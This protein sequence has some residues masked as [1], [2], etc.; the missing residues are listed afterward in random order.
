MNLQNRI[1]L[2]G[3]LADYLKKNDEEWKSIKLKASSHNPWFTE[4]FIELATENIVNEYFD[5]SKI[6]NW[7][8]HYHLDDLIKP[9]NIGIVMAGNIPMV[10]CHDFL[11]TFI[12]GHKQTIKFSSK[13]N[14]LLNHLIHKLYEL[15]IRTK[16]LIIIAENLKGCDA[17][18]A[19]GGSQS[20]VHF[21]QYFA[22]YPHIIRSNRTS[23]A[24][25][26][27]TETDEELLKLSKDIHYYFGLGCR[28][29]TKIFV[30]K[31]YDFI[32]LLNS[33]KEFSYFRDLN[34]YSNNYDYQL[35]ILLLNNI[36]YMT[37]GSILLTEESRIFSP[38]SVLHYEFYENKNSLM[39][40]LQNNEDI[41]CIIGHGCIEFGKAQ[42]PDLFTYADGVDIMEF[43]LSL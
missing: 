36:K 1:D 41:Q 29:V 16:E 11:S 17:Y 4:K 25:L 42:M 26:D 9:Q 13:D 7:V 21:R 35:S 27:G 34:K 22:K 12:C 8:N 2:I 18:I 6:N 33:F 14:I 15:D 43:L 20:A 40:V 24:I 32:P 19:T 23:L 37:N 28:N 39:E 5:T 30:P 3:L 10:G 38:I 31:D